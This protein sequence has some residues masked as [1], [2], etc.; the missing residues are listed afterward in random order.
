MDSQ[1]T[2][3][4][5]NDVDASRSTLCSVP[6]SLA[7]YYQDSH[8]TIYHGDCREIL[9]MLGTFGTVI[10][11]PPYPN[12][13]GH[14][15]DGIEAARQVLGW[16]IAQQWLVF[17]TEMETP[18]VQQP[19]VAVHVWHRSNTN[20]PDNYEPI[21]HFA[22]D[23]KK[24]ASRVLSHP[25]IFTGLTGCR[26]AVGHPTQKNEKLMRR[27]IEMAKPYGKLCDPFMGSGSTLV[28]AKTEGAE[29]VGIEKDERW[30]ELAAERLRQG[31]L[32]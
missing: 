20:R 14:F 31:V 27:L 29:V 7:P 24:R 3:Q 12:N 15:D 16:N 10:T 28:A 21:Y 11:D 6:L 30:C 8:C 22:E 19:K 25:V 4:Q 2:S 13:A 18:P 26:E 5:T 9:P 23:G 1:K 32:F 17:W